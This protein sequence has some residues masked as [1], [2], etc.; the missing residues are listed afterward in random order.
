[1]KGLDIAAMKFA[2]I[3]SVPP[4][5][6]DD[7]EEIRFHLGMLASSIYGATSTSTRKAWT[8]N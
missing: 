6:L 5:E 1:M 2:A 4:P 8:S 7:K 3:L